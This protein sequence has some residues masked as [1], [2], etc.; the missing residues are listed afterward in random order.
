[1]SKIPDGFWIFNTLPVCERN[2]RN[3]LCFYTIKYFLFE[4]TV[5]MIKKKIRTSKGIVLFLCFL[6][7]HKVE[8]RRLERKMF[9]CCAPKKAGAPMCA[10]SSHR[11]AVRKE[12]Q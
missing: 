12:Q 2:T 3:N 10:K 5:E 11:K 1:M 9:R 8:W 7:K 6:E 4:E